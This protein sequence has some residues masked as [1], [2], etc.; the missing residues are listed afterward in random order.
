[1]DQNHTPAKALFLSDVHLGGFDER[2]NTLLEQELVNL[3]DYCETHGYK[4]YVLG[5]LFD[6]W[7][8]YPNHIPP[9]AEQVRERFKR[10]NRS[11]GPTL[12]ITGNHDNWT[13]DYLPSIGFELEKDL[14]IKKFGHHKVLMLHGDGV[15]NG[16]PSLSRPLM[17]RLLRNPLFIRF[18]QKLLPPS[19]GLKAMKWFSNINRSTGKIQEEQNKLNKWAETKLERED[20]DVILCGH[21]HMPRR[22]D[23]DFG[24]YINLG[25][26]CIHRT[27]V[28]YNKEG[29]SLVSWNDKRNKLEPF[30]GHNQTA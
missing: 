7:M 24:T 3:I 20:I 30:S 8:E 23:F 29:F 14:R 13:R 18:Y 11:F 1:M 25:T 2:R 28:I 15:E 4:I 6:Y 9:V 27:A 17:H 26:F 21:D 16:G 12:F 5:D 19:M 10:Y 22:N